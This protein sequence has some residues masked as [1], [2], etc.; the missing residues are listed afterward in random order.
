MV[1][2]LFWVRFDTAT[3]TC[4]HACCLQCGDM[5]RTRMHGDELAVGGQGQ[6]Q[7]IVAQGHDNKV[8]S[9]YNQVGTVLCDTATKSSHSGGKYKWDKT[10][11]VSQLYT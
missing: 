8:R 2:F 1:S 3:W 5:V 10:V 6:G 11:M 7:G 9:E 4:P